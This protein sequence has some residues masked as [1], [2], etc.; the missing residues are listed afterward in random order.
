MESI[1][2][3]APT[4]GGV[5]RDDDYRKRI[6]QSE[7]KILGNLSFAVIS[8]KNYESEKKSRKSFGIHIK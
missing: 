3:Q 5:V 2:S 6:L 1:N 4:N 7:L 8:A